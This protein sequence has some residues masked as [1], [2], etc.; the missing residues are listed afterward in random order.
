M[1]VVTSAAKVRVQCRQ[2]Y[3]VRVVRR[4]GLLK[5]SPSWMSAIRTG[6]WHVRLAHLS[7]SHLIAIHPRSPARLP[8]QTRAK[9]TG[10]T[11]AAAAAGPPGSE[12]TATAVF[13]AAG[14][15]WPEVCSPG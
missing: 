8:N 5:N 4:A 14:E 9:V 10:S 13:A 11:R 2:E 1:T 3:P 15:A 7:A 6:P 12:P